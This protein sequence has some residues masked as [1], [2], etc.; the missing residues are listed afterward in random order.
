M[1]TSSPCSRNAVKTEY[2]PVSK[3]LHKGLTCRDQ[4]SRT[5]VCSTCDDNL[6][7][8]IELS[9]ERVLIEVFDSIPQADAPLRVRIVVGQKG[10]KSF[11]AGV[12]DPF[13]GR[14]VHITL[15]KV[16]TIGGQVDRA[17]GDR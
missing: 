1:I 16:D 2:C 8:Y 3:Q 6:G 4:T 13:G 10:F 15:S 7:L 11:V 5:L 14:K 9:I 12:C 17:A